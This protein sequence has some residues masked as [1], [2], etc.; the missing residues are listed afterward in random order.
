[1][2]N[3]ALLLL[4]TAGGVGRQGGTRITTNPPITANT[5]NNGAGS[6]PAVPHCTG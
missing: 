2:T 3:N 6:V 1:V 5:P 4:G